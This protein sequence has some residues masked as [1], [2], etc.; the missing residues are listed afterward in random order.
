MGKSILITGASSGIGAATA[1]LMA[2]GNDRV[3]H[4]NNSQEQAKQVAAENKEPERNCTLGTS[5]SDNGG[6]L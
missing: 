1:K 2:A 5:R 4:Y 3:V 6:K